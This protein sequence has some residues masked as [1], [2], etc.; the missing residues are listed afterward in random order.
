MASNPAIATAYKTAVFRIHNPSRHKRAMLNDALTRNHRAYTKLLDRLL[1]HLGEFAKHR[2]GKWRE[3]EIAKHATPVV[4]PLPLS[5]GA[6]A[7]LINDVA[8]Q[9]SSYIELQN[10]QENASRPT[11]ARLNARQ[12][13]YETSLIDVASS[14]TL[15]AENDARNRLFSEIRAGSR[16][17]ILFLK[18]RPADGYLILYSPEK[19]DYYVWLNLHPKDSRF[20]APV[21]I[22]ELIDVR[23]GEIFSIPRGSKTGAIFPIEFGRDFQFEEFMRKGRPQSAKLLERGGNYEIHVTFEYETPKLQPKLFLGVDRG[24]YNLASLSV[25]DDHGNIIEERNIDGMQ[26]R[27]VQ[28]VEE[29]RQRDTQRRGRRYKSRSRLAMADEAVHTAA[30]AIVE[31]ALE[32]QAQVVLEHLG[33]LTSRG[34]KRGRSNFNRVLNRSQY[35][36]LQKVL[37][38][39]LPV[40]GLPKAKTVSAAYTSQT[41]PQ[42]GHQ[43]RENRPKLPDGDGFILDRFSCQSCGYQADADLNAAQVIAIK[44]MWRESLPKSQRPKLMSE[45]AENYSFKTYLRDRAAMRGKRP[46]D[47]MVDTSGAAGLEQG[48]TTTHREIGG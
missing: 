9:L 25:V 46:G 16:R 24:I 17:P 38:Y 36:K 6:K 43:D 35:Q 13:D 5:I 34:K 11:A 15:D 1:P 29:R 41:C 20:A 45:L 18:N 28:R 37:E 42:C 47:R 14:T 21:K 22:D 12:I 19:K 32:H 7:G 8:G 40:V 3:G 44:R 48:R 39:K 31:M 33:N 4:K 23:T 2:A 27:H 26:L 10:E 30:N